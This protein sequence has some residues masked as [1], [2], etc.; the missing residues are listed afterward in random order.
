MIADR[1]R[2]LSLCAVYTARAKAHR[3]LCVNDCPNSYCTENW[4]GFQGTLFVSIQT[5][6]NYQALQY[7]SKLALI[8]R[9]I[10][11]Q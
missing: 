4:F 10:I 2:G 5:P 7:A 3:R 8:S 11:L 1:I 6:V 9:Q